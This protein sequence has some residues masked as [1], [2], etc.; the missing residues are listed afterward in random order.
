MTAAPAILETPIDAPDHASGGGRLV[1]TDGRILPLESASLEATARGGI[2]RAVLTQT[3][4]N[5]HDAALTVKYTLPLPADG[6]VSGF[7]FRV[8][9]RRVVG[10]I[11]RREAARERF[12]EAVAEGRSAAILEQERSNMFTQEVGNIPA[13]ETVVCETIVDQPLAWL[14]EGMWEWR[15]PTVVGPRYLGEPGRVE[16]AERVTVDVAGGELAVRV[17][18]ALEIGDALAG[19]VESASHAVSES[20]G[21]VSFASEDGARLDRDVVIRWPVAGHEVGV[22]LACCRPEG[23]ASAYG[24]LTAVPPTPEAGMEPVPRDLIL[25][26]DTSGSMSGLPLDYA[27]RIACALI[28]SLGEDDR[29]EM[30]EFSSAPRRWHKTAVATTPTNRR[31]AIRWV[32]RLSAGGATEM[33]SGMLEAMKTLRRGSQRQVLLVTDGYVGFESEIV[34]TAIDELPAGCR[35]HTLGVGSAVNRSLLGPV[36]R[37]GNGACAIAA[38]DEDVERASQRLLARMNAPL[39]TDLEITGDAVIATAPIQLPD[40]YAGSPAL[41][42]LELDPAGGAIRVR[43]KTAAGRF[44]HRIEAPA[45]S[46]GDGDAAIAALFG[47]ERVEDLETRR[48]GGDDDVDAEIEE[49]GLGFQISTRLTSWVAIGEVVASDGEAIREVMPHEVPHGTAVEGF[50]LRPAVMGAPLMMTRSVPTGMGYFTGAPPAGAPAQMQQPM[51]PTPVAPKKARPRIALF[52]FLVLVAGL[53]V[54]LYFLLS[55]LI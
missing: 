1:A 36:A 9:D 18:L 4:V 51:L 7:S 10:E 20:S 46:P 31:A 24:L 45:Q 34:R 40:L 47:R 8:G 16:D 53:A 33:R 28:D 37:A 23:D 39:V 48:A 3:F 42:N 19:A 52:W 54:A 32:K 6:A 55:W 29:L 44:D 15:F 50:G 5:H 38:L 26:I 49:L 25:L 12:E 27:R 17:S 14:D 41:I 43:G 21:R 30:V 13:G 22:S 35:L 2:A 11:D